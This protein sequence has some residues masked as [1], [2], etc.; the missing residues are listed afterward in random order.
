MGN[1]KKEVFGEG[2]MLH[3]MFGD[4]YEIRHEQVNMSI[5]TAKAIMNR[6][7]LLA[8]GATG[9]G[10][11][12]AYILPCV[13]PATRQSFDGPVIISTSTKV[14]QDQIYRKDV[15]AILQAT[16]QPLD[17]VLA[18]GRNNYISVRR[19]DEYLNQIESGDVSF[20]SDDVTTQALP[21]LNSVRQSLKETHGEFAN[22][23][24][25]V[26]VEIK[27]A[28]ESTDTD[29]HGEDCASYDIC[30]YQKAKQRRKQADILI[31]NHAL[32][33]LHIAFGR[34]LP[35]ESPYFHYR[36]GA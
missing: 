21:L 12:F 15:P 27:T 11:S 36:R 10:K 9:V 2:G 4:G 7:V 32:L 26:P 28:I 14:L 1:F 24:Q 13:S 16:E 34:I 20:E 18:K 8:E 31:V 35:Q 17:V 19:L 22:F 3:R 6:E 29:C 23:G 25:D 33:A 5:A 30:P